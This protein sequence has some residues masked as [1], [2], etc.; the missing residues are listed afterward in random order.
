MGKSALVANIAE[1]AVLAGHAVALF[2]LEMSESEL[3]QRFVASQARIKGEDLRRGRVAEQR[4]RRSSRPASGWREAPLYVDDSSDTGRARGPG[5][6]PPA[7]QPGRG[8][9]RA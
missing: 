7:A 1:N 2:S 3:A 4:G 9:P 6:G 8:R 5:Q